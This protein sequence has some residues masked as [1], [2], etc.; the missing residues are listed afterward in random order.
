[1]TDTVRDVLVGFCRLA[2]VTDPVQY[3]S[4]CNRAMLGSS[5]HPPSAY[6]Y[7]T[8]LGTIFRISNC[9]APVDL[10]RVGTVLLT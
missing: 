2:H 6:P 7:V 9:T 5:Y 8:A 1:M 10:E 4:V 3:E